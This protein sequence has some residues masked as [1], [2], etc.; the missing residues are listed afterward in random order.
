MRTNRR[1]VNR[2]ALL[3]SLVV[4]LT[5][6]SSRLQADTGTCGGVATTLQF[7]V[8]SSPFFCQMAEAFF[9]GLTNGTSATT[10]SPSQNVPREQMAA[11]ITRRRIREINGLRCD[12]SGRQPRDT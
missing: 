10:Y 12:S 7:T 5:I 6:A 8:M 9:S 4:A 2:I 3:A 11:F 1:F